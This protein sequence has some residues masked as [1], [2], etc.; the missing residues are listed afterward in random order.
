M[1]FEDGMELAEE[2]D[3]KIKLVEILNKTKGVLDGQAIFSIIV[4]LIFQAVFLYQLFD[5]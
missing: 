5:F 3:F 4:V 2:A 1:G